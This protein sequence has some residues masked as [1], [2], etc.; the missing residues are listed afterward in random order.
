MEVGHHQIMRAHGHMMICNNSYK[1]E[2]NF[3]IFQDVPRS[4]IHSPSRK[5]SLKCKTDPYKF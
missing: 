1:S 4:G 3:E 5:E 2:E